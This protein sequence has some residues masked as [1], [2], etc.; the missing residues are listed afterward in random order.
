MPG[1]IYYIGTTG[2]VLLVINGSSHN[3]HRGQ[4]CNGSISNYHPSIPQCHL[5]TR[6]DIKI[7]P[8]SQASPLHTLGKFIVVWIVSK[9]AIKILKGLE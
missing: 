6:D 9:Y 5:S 8:G 7:W 2:L 4:C 3:W 1:P